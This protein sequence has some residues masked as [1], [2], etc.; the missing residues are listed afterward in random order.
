MINEY[1]SE[2]ELG[3]AVLTTEEINYKV[4]NGVISIFNKYIQSFAK[5]YPMY[6]ED[7]DSVICDTNLSLLWSSLGAEIP[8]LKVPLRF[9][10]NEYQ[11]DK[12]AFL[13]FLEFCYKHI[14]D[15]EE[16]EPHDYFKHHHLSFSKTNTM[17][18]NFRKE[19][20]RIFG[21]N[22][23][24]FYLNEF[25]QIK[26]K[27]PVAMDTVISNI[28]LDTSDTRLNE[29]VALAI[30]NIQ[31]AKLIDRIIALEK[32]WDAFE[33]MKTYY[34]AE[35]KKSAEQL[36]KDVANKTD[37]FDEVLSNEFK[38]LTEIG[39]KY[40]IRHFENGKI[41]INSCEHIDY[42]FYRMLSVIN[43]CVSILK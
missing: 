27:L 8:N 19:V 6:C 30:N 32:L 43:L 18:E 38:A 37:K 5:D 42:L 12:Y 1:F 13:D 2:R 23:I 26:R 17:K 34:S 29:L 9:V 41:Q 33:R 10:E 11:F 16:Y 15:V 3:K 24:I 4:F 35:K 40:Q 14:Y 39:N 22:S 25:G 31:N 21:R 36:I 28:N 20:N 7:F